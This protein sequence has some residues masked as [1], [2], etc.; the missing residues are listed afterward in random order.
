MARHGMDVRPLLERL[1]AAI[2]I[3]RERAKLGE[4]RRALAFERFD[5][6]F[7]ATVPPGDAPAGWPQVSVNRAIREGPEVMLVS[8]LAG[9]WDVVARGSR[10]IPNIRANYG[11]GILPSLFG[12]ELFW[13]D[14]SL[15]TLPTTKPLDCDDPIARLLDAGE[16]ELTSGLGA[17][18]FEA[19]DCF[20]RALAPYPR[21]AEAVWVY[22]PDLQGPLDAA[23]LLAG[24]GLYLAFYDAPDRV[25]ALLDLVTRTY[26]R[27]MRE[28]LRLV[29]A[30]GSGEFMAHWGSLY[31]GQVML[32]NDSLVNLSAEMYAELV[33]PFDER[34]LREFGGGAVHFCGKVEHCI[35][36][37]ASCEGLGGV[38]I[39]QPH[40]NDMRR[41]MGA[42]VAR[43]KILNVPRGDWATG[44][45][46]SRGVVFA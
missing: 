33:R 45:D 7:D 18:V 40:L 28:W 36:V 42:T 14:D 44:L 30:R 10:R 9:V 39:S 27:F 3:D 26:V 11:T 29:P 46:V 31:R 41:V 23:E 24:P 32:R 5:G 8:Q 35:E 2:D 19:T 43:G 37:V 34:I 25:R 6:G 1:E 16:P 21:L 22:H 17:R 38:N 4:W 12:A 20:A 13:M 15:D